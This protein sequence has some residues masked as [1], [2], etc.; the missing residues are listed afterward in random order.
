MLSKKLKK[1]FERECKYLEY[2]DKH[3]KFPFEKKKV[4]ITLSNEIIE[5]HKDKENFSAFVESKIS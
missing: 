3:L 4:T 1:A 5:K 2:Y